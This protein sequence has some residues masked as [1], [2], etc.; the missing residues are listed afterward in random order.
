MAVADD[1]RGFLQGVV[2]TPSG[3]FNVLIGPRDGEE[4]FQWPD[5]LDEII[6]RVL[7][8][9]DRNVFFSPHLFAEPNSSK[10]HVL[11]TRTIVADLDN[12]DVADLVI[13]PTFLVETS[14]NRHQGY[15][16]IRDD[17]PLSDLELLSKK[18]SYTIPDCDHSGWS[19]GH[20]F[21]VPGTRNFKYDT[22]GSVRLA[23]IG[24][25]ER[26]YNVDE[27]KSVVQNTDVTNPGDAANDA[28][29]AAPPTKLAQGPRETLE[30]YREAIGNKA[31]SYYSA[32][33][34]DRSEALWFLM[35]ALF[36]AG[37][38]KDE[39]YWIVKHSVN[40]KFDDHKYNAERDLAKDVDR[41]SRA[42]T[43]NRRD[44][45]SLVIVAEKTVGSGNDRKRLISSIVSKDMLSKGE[46]IYTDDGRYWYLHTNAGRPIAL[47]RRSE[48]LDSFLDSTY[49]LN[50]SDGHHPYVV[51]HLISHTVTSGRRAISGVLSYFDGESLLLHSGKSDVYRITPTTVT[52]H[53]DGAQGVLFPW[54]GNGEEM[55]VLGD[56]LKE[57]WADW[58]FEGWFTNLLELSPVQAKTLMKI[59]VLF[60]L[61]RELAVSRPI[62][63]LLGQ[64][65]SGKSTLFRLIYTLLYGRH[66]SLNAISNSDDFDFLVSVDPV[67]V[68]DNVDTWAQWL[69]D[70]LALSAS[71][72]DLIKR[73]LYTDSDTVVLKRQA[74]VGLTAHD[75]RF[76]RTDV[77]DRMIILNFQRRN[78]FTPESQ[79]L[80]RVYKQRSALWGSIVQDVQKI[81]IEP[82]PGDAEIPVFR[83]SDFARIG[84]RIAKALGV[85]PIFV[86]TINAMRKSQT[87]FSL[88]EEDVLVDV[89]KRW[90]T[91]R[92]PSNGAGPEYHS[93]GTLWET[94]SALEPTFQ[95]TYKSSALLS[96]RLWTMQANLKTVFDVDFRYDNRRGVRLWKIDEVKE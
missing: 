77:I 11:P 18:L 50:P 92:R 63:T 8:I 66:K 44:I 47:T 14:N 42:D 30:K 32:R 71:S 75:P 27:I 10:Q 25:S 40:N 90:Q 13:G 38:S 81:L 78:A 69:P 88:S 54:R 39:V 87:A 24:A 2:T 1:L 22:P 41:A 45:K 48:Q 3:W 29:I 23:I 49:G 61:F 26:T 91:V 21:R 65:G 6:D 67:V 72:S 51:N 95:R 36:R 43:D 83:I 62:L 7:S 5:Q 56:P 60:V 57:D 73:K 52:R 74:I 64:P 96:R 16:V 70:R 86:D 59:W 76:G 17:V 53:P 12:A 82:N 58:L 9:Q 85:Y 33:Q 35:M 55:I 28:W 37:A 84:T 46:F 79:I 80:E 20:R 94:L 89:L 4:W 31:F 34:G 93:V 15:W 19:V 68:F